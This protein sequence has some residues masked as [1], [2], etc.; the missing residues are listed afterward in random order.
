MRSRSIFLFRS[1]VR[2]RRLT[3]ERRLVRYYVSRFGKHSYLSAPTLGDYDR[4][5][6]RTCPFGST[7]AST[8]CDIV[9]P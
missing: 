1:L 3:E 2:Q 4:V 7:T 9:R 5:Q 8:V 6:S